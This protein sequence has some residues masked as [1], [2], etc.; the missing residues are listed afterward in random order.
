MF[1]RKVYERKGS[2]IRQ[3]GFKSFFYA[4]TVLDV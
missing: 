1:E 3:Q 4:A 2:A